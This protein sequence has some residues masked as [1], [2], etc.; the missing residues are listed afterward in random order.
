MTA[1]RHPPAMRS[2]RERGVTLVELLVAMA[3]GLVVTLAVT[4]AVIFGEA[5]KRSTTAINDMGQS[6]AY[7]AYMLDRA[8]RSAGSGLVQSWDLG[9][10]GCKLH[11]KRTTDLPRA[12]AFPPP[13]EDFL[14]GAVGAENLRVAPLLIAK[15]QSAGGSDVL[16]VM[17]GN[18]GAGDVPRPILSGSA[19]ANTLRLDN[20][21]RIAARDVALVSQNG[22]EDC[23]VEHVRSTFADAA[24]NETLE[25]DPNFHTDADALYTLFGGGDAFLTVLGNAA[26]DNVQFQLFGVGENRTL[27]SHDVLQGDGND[28]S[29]AL[30]DGVLEMHALYGLDTNT[31]GI[32][33]EW[34]APDAVGYDITTM[35][36]TPERARQVVAVRVGL[37]LRGALLEKEPVSAEIP[38]MFSDT[39]S[40]RAAV[41]LTGDDRRY[42]YQVVEFTVPLRNMPLAPPP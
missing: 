36:T 24:S 19:V 42:R 2:V 40:E 8:I 10:F 13:F 12:T 25:L 3:I 7:T 20:T 28:A 22:F 9:V 26:S 4:S 11:A 32:F 21:V 41:T 34:V 15:D 35:M 6:G 14:G 39:T 16:V 1:R 33:D 30:A 23:L 29:R 5:T 27:F 17:G 31:D 37:V 18:S 38:A